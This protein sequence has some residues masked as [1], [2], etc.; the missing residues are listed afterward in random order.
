MSDTF[1][2]TVGGRYNPMI[3]NHCQYVFWRSTSQNIHLIWFPH[4]L[5]SPGKRY[6]SKLEI[7]RKCFTLI[8]YKE[9]TFIVLFYFVISICHVLLAFKYYPESGVVSRITFESKL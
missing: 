7:L 3:N 5:F 1:T 9:E 8:F 4:F 2:E 6:P